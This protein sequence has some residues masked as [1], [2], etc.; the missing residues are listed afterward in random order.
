MAEGWERVADGGVAGAA[1]QAGAMVAGADGM[2]AG[3]GLGPWLRGHEAG[4]RLRQGRYGM[5]AGLVAGFDNHCARKS[6]P[7]ALYC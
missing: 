5:V 3:G 4:C 7:N 2:V 1:G 6:A